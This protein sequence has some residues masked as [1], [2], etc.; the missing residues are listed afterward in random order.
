MDDGEN[1][2]Y[3]VLAAYAR[4]A[5]EVGYCQG[6]NYLV[7]LILIGVNFDEVTA[8]VVLEQLMGKYELNSL[9]G[10]KLSKLFSL[11]DII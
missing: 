4:H 6:M 10:G 1:S 5:P 2:L 7:G 11:S 9:Y 8:F 3:N